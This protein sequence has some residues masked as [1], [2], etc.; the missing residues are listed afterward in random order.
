MNNYYIYIYLDITKP[1]IYTYD[2]L[3]FNFE[4]FYVGKGK[5]KRYYS[6]INESY[7][8][9]RHNHKLNRIRLIRKITNKNPEIIKIYQNLNEIDAYDLELKTINLIG[10]FDFGFG[11][12]LNLIDGGLGCK[13]HSNE[14]KKNISIKTK[15]RFEDPNERIKTSNGLKNSKIWRTIITSS[16]HR[17]KLSKAHL[18]PNSNFQ[19]LM[20]SEKFSNIMSIAKTGK[21]NHM[22]GRIGIDNPRYG[23]GKKVYQYDINSVLIKEWNNANIASIELNIS[24]VCIERRCKNKSNKLYKNYIWTY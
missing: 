4:P 11:P 10:R 13:S 2:K 9:K 15:K 18:N 20:K 6:H 8:S 19:L 22:F 14:T 12:L 21:K 16:E 1:G 24:R 7:D 5:N 23:T 3:K 17:K